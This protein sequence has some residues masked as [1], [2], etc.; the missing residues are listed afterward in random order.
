MYTYM[1]TQYKYLMYHRHNWRVPLLEVVYYHHNK[2][3]SR[4]MSIHL[5]INTTYLNSH[6][7]PHKNTNVKN[8]E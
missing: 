8:Q 4:V 6:R 3:V 7:S 5:G 2:Y 1:H